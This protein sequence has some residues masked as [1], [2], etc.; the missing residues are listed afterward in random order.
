MATGQRYRRAIAMTDEERDAFLAAER[1]C[2]VATVAADGRPHVTPLWFVWHDGAV[3]LYSLNR[4]RRF[5]DVT[6]DPRVAVVMD[7]GEDFFEQRGVEITGT[8]AVVGDVPRTETPDPELAEPERLFGEK[9]FGG[10]GFAYD[11]RHAWLRVVPD[12]IVSWD[13]AKIG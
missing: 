10:Q 9:Y 3:W 4:S 2:R 12:T 6:A 13:H 8:A 11:G 7:G 1:T 5:E